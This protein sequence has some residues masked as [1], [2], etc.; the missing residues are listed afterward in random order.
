MSP[1]LTKEEISRRAKR[2]GAIYDEYLA[3][4]A[5]LKKQQTEM[6]DRFIKELEQKKIEEIR[7]RLKK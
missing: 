7:A 1:K 6:I 3:K 2:I 4:L 5:M